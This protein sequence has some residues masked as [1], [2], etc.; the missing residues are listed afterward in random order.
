[1]SKDLNVNPETITPI[2]VPDI[3]YPEDFTFWRRNIPREQKLALINAGDF[4][5][6]DIL[7]S[8]HLAHHPLRNSFGITDR[9]EIQSRQEIVTFLMKNKELCELICALHGNVYD[10]TKL[11][12]NRHQFSTSFPQSDPSKKQVMP[13][14]GI[15]KALTKRLQRIRRKMALPPKISQF[16]AFLQSSLKLHETERTLFIFTRLRAT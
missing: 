2:A 5:I 12:V 11:P 6:K 16:L 1:M 7:E 14:W 3:P 8:L 9:E 13:Y 4:P 15:V 10:Y